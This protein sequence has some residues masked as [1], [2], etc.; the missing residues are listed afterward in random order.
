MRL[1]LSRHRRVGAGRDDDHVRTRATRLRAFRRCRGDRGADAGGGGETA[2]DAAETERR[3]H[4]RERQACGAENCRRP[5]T[6]RRRRRVASPRGVQRVQID[7]PAIDVREYISWGSAS[8]IAFAGQAVL[9]VFF[10]FFL[11]ASGDMFKRKLV[12]V[13]GPVAR[14]EEDHRPDPRTTS[15][16]RSSGSSSFGWSRASSSAWRRGLHSAWSV[17][18]RPACGE[19][20]P[21]SSTAFPTS[22]R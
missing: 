5:P 13:V 3:R 19:W 6:K 12:R 20:P 9:I 18:N 4:A 11:L 8:L 21:A 1:R 10:V 2:A 22:D 17:S 14:E 7:E 15:T 16:R